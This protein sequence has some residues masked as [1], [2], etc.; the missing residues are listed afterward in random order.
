MNV[1]GRHLLF[2]FLCAL[3][4]V[5]GVIG[6]Y[7]ISYPLEEWSEWWTVKAYGIPFILAL[8]FILIIIGISMGLFF[9]W[10]WK[11]QFSTI[12]RSLTQLRASSPKKESEE[13]HIAEVEEILYKIQKW[14][15]QFQEQTKLAQKLANQNAEEQEKQM[16]ELVS[17]ERS[18]LARELHDSVSQQ[19]FAA[20]MLISAIN[21]SEETSSPALQKQLK[22]IEQMVHQSQL[23]MRALLLHLRPVPLKGKSLKKGM[24]E[25]LAELKQKVPMEVKWK[26]ESCTLEKGIED[27][28]FRILQEAVS[29]TLRHSKASTLEVLFIVRDQF[30]I[31]RVVDDGIGFNVEEVK[32]TSYGLQTMRERAL[33]IGGNLQVVSLPGKGTRLEVKIPIMEGDDD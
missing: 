2:G 11:K 26:V 13:K 9:G 32:T 24:I 12:N 28:L 10:Y 5:I 18:R 22:M 8:L 3:A 23:E 20:S 30:A 14:Q 4:M 21:E 27:H 29:N 19:L 31:L 16:Q 17:K 33:E 15:E 7:L 1:I 6:L 25:L